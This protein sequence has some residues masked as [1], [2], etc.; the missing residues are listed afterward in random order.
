MCNGDNEDVAASRH[1][2]CLAIGMI[3]PSMCWYDL[4]LGQGDIALISDRNNEVLPRMSSDVKNT[5]MMSQNHTPS[6][7]L[8]SRTNIHPLQIV[9]ISKR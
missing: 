9:S 3:R 1:S 6:S 2:R 4:A 7:G 5:V 8:T